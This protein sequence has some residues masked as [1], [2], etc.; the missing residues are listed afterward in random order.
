MLLRVAQQWHADL[1]VMGRS[2]KRRPGVPY[3]GNQTEHLLEFASVPVLVVPYP[4]DGQR[5]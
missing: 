1:I 4:V 3:V 2:D 5:S